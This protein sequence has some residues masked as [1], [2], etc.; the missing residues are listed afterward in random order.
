VEV[1]DVD[2][3][4]WVDR[5]ARSAFFVSA[6]LELAGSNILTQPG[7]GVLVGVECQVIARSSLKEVAFACTLSITLP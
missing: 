1:F 2:P 7:F 6:E 5:L 3:I 4:A